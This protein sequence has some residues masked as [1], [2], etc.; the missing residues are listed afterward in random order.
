MMADRDINQPL[1]MSLMAE[2]FSKER[3][4]GEGL[5]EVSSHDSFYDSLS[6]LNEEAIDGAFPELSA[7]LS[8]DEINKS[9]DIAR[10]AF[11]DTKYENPTQQ[12]LQISSLNAGDK[13]FKE[14]KLS[15]PLLESSQKIDLS[16]CSVPKAQR[17]ITNAAVNTAVKDVRD[18]ISPLLTTSPSIIRTLQAQKASKK[19]G[20]CDIFKMPNPR[21]KAKAKA[22]Q[23]DSTSQNDMTKK[24][25]NF[26]EELSAIFRET[27]KARDRRPNGDSSSPDSGY[28]SPKIEK[29][30]LMNCLIS[31]TETELKS[32]IKAIDAPLIIEKEDTCNQTKN[33]TNEPDEN[34]AQ[35][36]ENKSYTPSTAARFVQKLRSQEVDEGSR[37]RLECRVTG[38]PLPEVRQLI[39]HESCHWRR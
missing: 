10:E 20:K 38:N 11:T 9:L 4:L 37:V 33:Q 17:R 19:S 18:M 29:P 31:E 25:A 1:P 14:I 23:C 39:Y 24:T 22:F 5:S 8:Q 15:N 36:V 34:E 30:T 21:T 3:T 28:L 26:I 7:F 32:D 6:D 13:S 27:S 2:D 16:H 12:S 35:I